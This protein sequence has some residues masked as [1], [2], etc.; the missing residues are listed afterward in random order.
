MGP[1]GSLFL[2]DLPFAEIDRIRPHLQRV[3]LR[4]HETVIEP[5]API[6]SV[7]LPEE[8]VLGQIV[9]LSE[10]TAVE[11]GMV[12]REGVAGLAAFLGASRSPDEVICQVPGTFLRMR[13]ADFVEQA[14]RNPVLREHLLRYTQAVLS[15]RAQIVACN[16]RH[17]VEAR[18]AR[19]L[20]KTHDR[21]EGDSF[22]VTHEVL[23]LMLG[24]RR[25]SVTPAARSLGR[26][27]LIAYRHGTLRIVDRAGLEQA[28]CEC[29]ST[30]RREF[31]RLGFSPPRSR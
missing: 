19:W 12:G 26:R 6:Q 9:T 18:L 28:A 25:P 21:V 24:V 13:A 7:Y 16:R 2:A 3:E 17:P 1:V 8:G 29:Y 10:G 27:G 22:P 20:L 31:E 5:D 30:I 23:A 4:L 15:W 14:Q 11:V